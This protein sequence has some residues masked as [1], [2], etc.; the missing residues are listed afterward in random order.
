[1]ERRLYF[2]LGDLLAVSASG[3]LAGALCAALF[4]TGWNMGLAMVAGMALGMLV[5]L[6][7]S[8]GLM[9]FFGAMEVMV[10]TMLGGMLSGMWIAMAAAMTPMGAGEGLRF[11]LLIGWFAWV[12]TTAF[13]VFLQKRG[14]TTNGR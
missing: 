3:A 9:P 11:G 2:V 6:P 7:C 1:M 12:A 10:P 5:A 14:S 8:F 4:G 13:H